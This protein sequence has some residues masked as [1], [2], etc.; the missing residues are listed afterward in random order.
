M[1][2]FSR[3]LQDALAKKG[4]NQKQLADASCIDQAHISIMFNGKRTPSVPTIHR[5]AKALGIS[6]RDLL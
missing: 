3:K 5:I 6:A 4:W 1:T 2:D